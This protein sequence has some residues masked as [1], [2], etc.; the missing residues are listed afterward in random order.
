M[1]GKT[2]IGCDEVNAS[3]GEVRIL[4]QAWLCNLRFLFVKLE[5]V[6]KFWKAEMVEYSEEERTGKV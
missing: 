6:N 5:T 4:T 2:N 3:E 1:G